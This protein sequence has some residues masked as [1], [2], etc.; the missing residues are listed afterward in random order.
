METKV[1]SKC[2]EE[3]NVC[4]FGNSK[5]SKDGL[6]YC[7]KEC[8][9]KRGQ[10]YHSENLEKHSNRT[11]K[12]Y[13]NNIDVEREKRQN[14]RRNNPDYNKFYYEN[15]KKFVNELNRK[16][17]ESN[18]NKLK[19]YREINRE[20][21][22]NQSKNRRQT[23]F[24]ANLSNRVR[25]RIG[26]YIKKNKIDKLK[27]KTFDIVGCTPEFL[28]EHLGTQFIDGMSWNNRSEWHI[29]HIIPLSSAKTEEELYKLCHY[30]NLQPLWAG[31]NLSKGNKVFTN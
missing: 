11:K 15:K 7:C 1:C 20:I 25:S 10:K 21:I 13:E 18:K 4:N 12:Y 3:K 6:L 5:S 19:E 24:I 30:S 31:D 16:W 2:K 8:N 17:R 9:R 28:K 27:N 22:N 23:N 26:K 29:D 14:W